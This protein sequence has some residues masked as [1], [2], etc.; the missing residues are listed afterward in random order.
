MGNAHRHIGFY[1][2]CN[3]PQSQAKAIAVVARLS[4]FEFDRQRH[5]ANA[6]VCG[7]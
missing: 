6:R 4:S 1:A 3:R 2:L 5:F 7:S